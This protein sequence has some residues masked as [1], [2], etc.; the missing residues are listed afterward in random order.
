MYVKQQRYTIFTRQIIKQKHEI[1][2]I[3]GKVVR[4]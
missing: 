1:A 3:I 4:K 2:S